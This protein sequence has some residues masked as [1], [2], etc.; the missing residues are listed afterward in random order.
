MSDEPPIYRV[1]ADWAAVAGLDLTI[2]RPGDGR[3]VWTLTRPTAGP[4]QV[5]TYGTPA[6][7]A[8]ELARV[9][10]ESTWPPGVTMP[11]P[12]CHICGATKPGRAAVME[13]RRWTCRQC[14]AGEDGC[15]LSLFSS[16]G[17][18]V[19]SSCPTSG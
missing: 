14:R 11:R 13:R 19:S 1:L 6:A 3:V 12:R 7:V 4:F 2:E 16:S 18:S 9:T 10:P 8:G 5:K 17:S 15:Q